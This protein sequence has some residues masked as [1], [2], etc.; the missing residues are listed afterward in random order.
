MTNPAENGTIKAEPRGHVKGNISMEDRPQYIADEL[1]VSIE[2]AEEYYCAIERWT[3]CTYKGI[4]AA[5]QGLT[6]N[7]LYKQYANSIE[8][9][10]EKA[11]AW[12][13]GE[14]FR[15]IGVSNSEYANL[16]KV[17][18]IISVSEGTLASWSSSKSEAEAFLEGT[19]DKKRIIFHC[20]TQSK[21]TSIAHLSEHDEKEVLVSSKALY[22][23]NSVNDSGYVTYVYVE[24]V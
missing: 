1:G 9:Y 23:V 5:Q 15:G 7:P 24:E 17:G 8:E 3:G 4:R 19:G 21:G 22:K 14:T 13:G 11:P 12:N 20:Q 16:T 6:A 2:K 18:D 10:V